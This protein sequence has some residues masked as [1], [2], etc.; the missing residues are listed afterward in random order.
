M[1]KIHKYLYIAFSCLIIGTAASA[2]FYGNYKLYHSP[3]IKQNSLKTLLLNYSNECYKDS[4][5]NDGRYYL[6]DNHN[7]TI[8][9][10]RTSYKSIYEHK[11][12]TFEGFIEYVKKLEK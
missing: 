6:I 9:V 12:P 5:L 11:Q 8:V 3:K 4:S 1:I 7:D 10:C 2:L